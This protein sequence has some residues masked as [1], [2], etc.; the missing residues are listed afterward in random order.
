MEALI[1]VEQ[2]SQGFVTQVLAQAYI[3]IDNNPSLQNITTFPVRILSKQHYKI[4]ARNHFA[5]F[6]IGIWCVL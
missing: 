3:F 4:I 5:F 2:I 1:D 6:L